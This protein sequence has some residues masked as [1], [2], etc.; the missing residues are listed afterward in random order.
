[1][2]AFLPAKAAQNP[3]SIE[4]VRLKADVNVVKRT[5]LFGKYSLTLSYNLSIILIISGKLKGGCDMV[6]EQIVEIISEKLDIPKETVKMESS[7]EELQA[8]SLYVVEIMMVIE[9]TFNIN[10]DEMK[11]VKTVGEIVSF[12]E[13]QI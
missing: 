10:I 11:E 8:D 2:T 3:P 5:V 6:F 7:F 1:M 13:A 12:V 9:E 4:K